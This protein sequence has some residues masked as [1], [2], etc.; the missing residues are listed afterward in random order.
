MSNVV[1]P[2]A[3]T[4]PSAKAGPAPMVVPA[5]SRRKPITRDR[6]TAILMVLPSIIAVA[7]FV[8]GFI[9]WKRVGV[10]HDW[11]GIGVMNEV[12]RYAS[13]LRTSSAC[14]TTSGSLA[15]IAS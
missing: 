10:P 9:A 5:R 3:P 8:Y 15:T 1:T 12:G 7:L 4:K 13:P 6:L 11:R 14:A 2:Q